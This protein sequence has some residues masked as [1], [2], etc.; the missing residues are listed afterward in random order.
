MSASGDYRCRSERCPGRRCRAGWARCADAAVAAEL[1]HYTLT[2][3]GD[4]VG[5]AL[6]DDARRS[7]ILGAIGYLVH[8]QRRAITNPMTSAG[9]WNQ[10]AVDPPSALANMLIRKRNPISAPPMKNQRRPAGAA[11]G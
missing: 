4:V 6:G 10:I 1:A 2:P 9:Q 8:A 3:K 7:R 5:F 11:C